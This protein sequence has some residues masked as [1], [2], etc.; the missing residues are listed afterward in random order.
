[1][2]TRRLALAAA[3]MFTACSG[4]DGTTDTPTTEPTDSGS[5]A[6]GFATSFT[7]ENGSIAG[8]VNVTATTES[9]ASLTLQYALADS[10]AWVSHPEVSTGTDHSWTVLGVKTGKEYDFQLVAT[11]SDERSA[12]Q[13]HRVAASDPS[14]PVFTLRNFQS[15]LACDSGGYLLLSYLGNRNSGLAILDR[16]ADI[17]WS[18]PFANTNVQLSRTRPSRIGQDIL[19]TTADGA[20]LEQIGEH[21]R[22][23][24]DGSAPEVLSSPRSHHDFVELPDGSLAWLAYPEFEPYDNCSV[25]T[26]LPDPVMDVALDR[27]E[28]GTFGGTPAIS[29]DMWT[30]YPR[31]LNC[32]VDDEDFLAPQNA[33]D[34]SH[35]N[36]IAYRI[37]DDAFFHMSRWQ[38]AFYKVDRTSGELVWELGGQHND[39]MPAKGQD[40]AELFNHSHMSEIWDGGLLIFNNNDFGPDAP[41]PSIIQEYRLDE[42]AMTWEVVWSWTSDQGFEALL[43]DARRMPY[44]TCDNLIVSLSGS[45]V[46]RELTRD[47]EFA[48]AVTA[49]LGNVT[50]RVTWIPN[51]YDLQTAFRE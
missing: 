45:G 23:P 47:G 8:V 38:D 3:L 39:F 36:S 2:E 26:S 44:S 40:A 18:V 19:Y 42:N 4:D 24:L 29:Y 30:D 46:V 9:D 48:W 28:T 14:V 21:V 33:F 49:P 34:L 51:I 1:M 27:I 13:T 10:D 37:S 15:E 32:S 6:T 25:G 50:S 41:G 7:L 11:E 43:G 31:S 22:Q 16:D 20:R 35:S 17:V 5:P 12:T